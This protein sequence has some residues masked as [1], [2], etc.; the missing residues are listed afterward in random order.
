VDAAPRAFVELFEARPIGK[1]LVRV[2]H[3]DQ[4]ETA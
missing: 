3:D 1:L 4:E 2:A